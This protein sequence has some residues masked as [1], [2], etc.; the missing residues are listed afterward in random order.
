MVL[1]AMN[2]SPSMSSDTPIDAVLQRAALQQ[3]LQ[4]LT[5]SSLF[6][7]MGLLRNRTPARCRWRS[8]QSCAPT[9][10]GQSCTQVDGNQV[11]VKNT[12]DGV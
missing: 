11:I 10:P 4:A 8:Q 5:G 6:L 12:P 3:L 7:Q 1:D 9:Q 2:Q